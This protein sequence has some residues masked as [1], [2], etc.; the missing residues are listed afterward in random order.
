MLRFNQFHVIE[1]VHRGKE[2]FPKEKT[3][4]VFD[5]P[6][7][8][9]IRE[10]RENVYVAYHKNKRVAAVVVWKDMNHGKMSS[11]YSETHPDYQRFGIMRKLYDYIEKKTG[12]TLYP[13]STL[14]DDGHAFWSKYRPDSVK[15]DLRST[16]KHL[17][18]K[19]YN[20]PTYG[21]GVIERIGA[22]GAIVRMPNGN[23]YFIG[24]DEINKLD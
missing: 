24:S 1:S 22:K 13:S 16:K 6:P 5:T 19:E 23:N 7:K 17:V 9:T 4:L 15:D 10:P 14:S 20:H 3:G 21:P 18:G 11:Y 8:I 12:Q 2:V